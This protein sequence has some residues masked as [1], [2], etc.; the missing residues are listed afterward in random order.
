M[1]E[2][3]S[4]PARP[5]AARA[6]LRHRPQHRRRG[7]RPPRALARPAR[8]PLLRA[9]ARRLER[10][11][12]RRPG[13]P[14]ALPVRDRLRS[15]DLARRSRPPPDGAARQGRVLG[16][17]DQARAGRRPRR[18]SGLHAQGLHRRRLPR[19]RATA[20]RRAGR[21]LPAVRDPQRAHAGGDLRRW[22]GADCAR[23]AVRVPVPARHGRAALRAGRR[24]ARTAGSAGRAA[25]TR[26]SAPTRRCSPTSCGACSRTAPTPRS[27]TAS[28]TPAVRDRRAGRGPGR[29]GR[30]NA[31]SRRR[32]RR[33]RRIRRS[34]CRASSTAPS[35]TQF[36]RPRPRRTKRSWRRCRARRPALARER[37]T[38]RLVA[39]APHASATS[40][41]A[42]TRARRCAIP[43]TT[44]TSSATS[45]GDASPTSTRALACAR[46]AR[47][48]L[49][50]DAAGE[51]APRC[52][53]A[54]PICS[55]RDMPRLLGLLVARGRQ[56]ATRTRVGEVREAVDFLRYYA[57][58][59]AARVR[60]R[61]RT[62]R[63][64]RSSA[65]ARGIFRSR[66][67]PA[68][69]PRRSPPATRCSPSRP[70]RR[71]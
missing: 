50:R 47:A 13:V 32:H 5:R 56:D 54:P 26:R 21:G 22:P 4:A 2:L 40:A 63:S 23:R 25:S 45:R 8:A 57:A 46:A 37:A 67:S 55:R 34:R 1:A 17:R 39:P 16:Q 64:A 53:S 6:P 15:I 14:E 43:P 12:L 65:S 9:R 28:P 71:R 36:A 24:P 58:Q 48:G 3:L 62:C 7:G 19:L 29:D 30:A 11:R 70:S 49:G 20:A 51:R 69:S 31:P 38:T 52:S 41:A 60:R 44:T 10:H 59:V 35:A 66:S 27:S 61:R 42:A 68:R 33:P 18:L